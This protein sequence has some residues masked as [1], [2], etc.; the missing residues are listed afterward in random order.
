MTFTANEAGGLQDLTIGAILKNKTDEFND[1]YSTE[2]QKAY[3]EAIADRS[4]GEQARIQAQNAA[5]SKALSEA[6]QTVAYMYKSSEA[7]FDFSTAYGDGLLAWTRI[8][9]PTPFIRMI[10]LPI[11]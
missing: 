6:A 1:S 9:F 11:T 7:E 2:Y 5:L 8:P 4:S 10:R 3:N